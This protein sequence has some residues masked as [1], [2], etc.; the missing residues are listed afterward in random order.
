MFTVGGFTLMSRILGFVRDKLITTYLGVGMVGDAWVAAFAL[1]NMFRRIFGEGAFNSAFVPLYCRKIKEEGDAAANYFASRVI[2]LLFWLLLGIFAVMFL[3]M[4]QIILATNWGFKPDPVVAQTIHPAVG[5]ID[6]AVQ[7]ATAIAQQS[8]EPVDRRLELATTAG[9]ITIAY[10]IFICLMAA[11]SGVL[12]SRKSYGPPAFAYVV[13]NIVL[14]AV[15]I[16]AQY[17]FS[18]MLVALSW[19]VLIA[20]VLQLTVVIAGIVKARVKV[21]FV[22]PVIDDDVKKLGVLMVPGLISAGIQQLNL[23]VGGI[24]ASLAMGGK[25]MIYISDRINQ[26]PLGIIGIAAGV[27]L[28]PEITRALRAGDTDEAKNRLAFGADMSILL[29]IPAMI[30]MVVIPGPIMHAIFEGGAAKADDIAPAGNVLRAFAIGMPAYVLARVYQPGFYAREDTKTPMRF[31]IVTA[32]VNIVLCY[33]MFLW[34]GVAGCALATSIA[35]WC[36]VLLLW[37]RLRKDD[38]VSLSSTSLSRYAR[39]LV[40]ALAMGVAIFFLAKYGEPWI[41]RE[42]DFIIRMLALLLLVIIGVI[43]YF[44]FVFASRV[45]SVSEFKRILKRG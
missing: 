28:L 2:T 34:L 31:A 23:L 8:A 12:N 18:D 37:S 20:G 42:G 43:I 4:P 25:S 15:M 30:A 21:G 45:L 36:N 10:M 35:G 11:F 24:V 32:I 33:P 6:F 26:L 9:R 29:C 14:I 7:Q 38:F 41:M 19:G 17:F 44:G 5:P 39:M 16:V 1:P 40:S 3:F 27:V 22:I 13:L